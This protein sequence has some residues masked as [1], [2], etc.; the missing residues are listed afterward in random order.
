MI[1]DDILY[2]QHKFLNGL[3]LGLKKAEL[4]SRAQG[5]H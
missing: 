4:V 5:A 3:F 2:N 1:D